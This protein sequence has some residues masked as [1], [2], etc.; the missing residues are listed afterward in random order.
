MI[1]KNASKYVGGIA[2]HWYE[3]FNQSPTLLDVTHDYF[4]ELPILMTEACTG[5][6]TIICR[7]KEINYTLQLSFWISLWRVTPGFLSAQT[8]KLN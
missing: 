2:V 8:F 3:D 4:P 5:K 1:N 7:D 6:I